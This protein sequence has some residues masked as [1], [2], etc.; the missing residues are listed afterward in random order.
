MEQLQVIRNWIISLLIFSSLI[1]AC[2][3]DSAEKHL[4]QGVINYH[5]GNLQ[6]AI[7]DFDRAIELDPNLA[8]AYGYRGTAYYLLED[9][10]Q[11]KQNYTKAIEL[12]PGFAD[13]YYNRG[14]I[15]Y[16]SSALNEAIDDFTEAIEL[17]PDDAQ[18]HYYRGYA[19]FTSKNYEAALNDFERALDIDPN[20][21]LEG[22]EFD[23]TRAKRQFVSEFHPEDANDYVKRGNYY[24]DLNNI[25]QA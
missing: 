16:E 1:T 24:F 11:A 20:L 10:E 7:Q 12:D 14:R 9:L 4:N 8:V 3:S 23:I 2:N 25:K 18:V 6:Q 15:Y 21:S 22:L 5:T 13:A 17:K 19:Y